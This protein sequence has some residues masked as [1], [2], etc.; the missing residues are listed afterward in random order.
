[1]ATLY[2]TNNADSG[3]GSFRDVLASSADGDVIKPDASAFAEVDEIEIRLSSSLATAKDLKISG[4]GKKIVFNAQGL[5]RVFGFSSGA[6]VTFEDCDFIGGVN[7]STCGGLTALGSGCSLYLKRC[8]VAGCQS[9]KPIGAISTASSS[10]SWETVTLYDSIITGVSSY[11]VTR[12]NELVCVGCTFVGNGYNAAGGEF[13]NCLME[14]E[15]NRPSSFGFVS[16][17]PDSIPYEDWSVDAWKSWDLRL[18]YDSAYLNGAAATLSDSDYYG[19]PRKVDGAIGAIEGSYLVIKNGESK[20]LS[21]ETTVDYLEVYSGGGLTL[22]ENFWLMVDRFAMFSGGSVV[23][24]GNFIIVPHDAFIKVGTTLVNVEIVQS[25][26]R[27][28]TLD[29][30]RRAISWTAEAPSVPVVLQRQEGDV[31][32]T[33]ANTNVSPFAVTPPLGVGEKIAAFDGEDFLYAVCESKILFHP[34]TVYTDALQIQTANRYNVVTG[35]ILMSE[36]YKRGETPL[37]FA[38]ITDSETNALIDANTIASI[39]YTAYKVTSTWGTITR[40]PV[41]GHENVAIPTSAILSELVTGDQRWTKDDDGYNFIYEPDSRVNTLF[42][43]AGDYVIAIKIEFDEANPLPIEFVI[44][45][46]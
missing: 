12:C 6:E 40:T 4:N 16:A 17:P 38:R 32:K 13:T 45:V 39:S 20:E 28:L 26:A 3:D 34:F 37:L 27:I 8:M 11:P 24:Q 23:G 25:S 7:T 30:T 19:D 21:S 1:M 9:A 14:D 2:F 5:S 44:S 15:A 18:S 46:N 29:A 41:E 43:D 36:Y 35:F 10:Y 22:T 42:S 31:W 33:I